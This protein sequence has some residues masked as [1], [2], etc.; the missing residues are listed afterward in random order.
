MS[1]SIVYPF[2]AALAFGQ[3]PTASNQFT[4]IQESLRH[5]HAANDTAAYL[6]ASHDLLA[7]LNGAPQSVLQLMS[8]QTFA[9]QQ[10]DALRSFGQFVAMGQAN[11]AVLRR[12]QFDALRRTPE[13]ATVHAAMAQNARS[14]SVASPVFTFPDTGLVP[15]DVDYDPTTSRFYITSVLKK[16][17]VAVTMTGQEHVFARAPDNWP[18]LALKL[19]PRRHLLWATEVAIDS[20]AASPRKDWGRSAIVIYDLATGALLHRVEG[21]AHTALGDMT[22]TAD[23][24]AIVSDGDNGGVYRVRRE[25][26]QL[27][28]L[29][30]GDFISP[31]T[32]AILPD[33]RRVLVPDY[34]RG[35]GVLDLDTKHVSWIPMDGR[36][37]LNGIDGLYLSGQTLI[38]TQNG[39][40]PERVV[41]F[42]LDSALLHV[43]SESIIERATPTLGDPTH[44]VIIGGYFYY[45][46]NSG[47]DTLDD[48]GRRKPGTTPTRASLMRTRLPNP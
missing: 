12:P 4:R 9:G 11:D 39:T 38:A 17:I 13:Y 33:G 32:P 5:A 27:E 42:T 36:H 7:L 28:R 15:E 48:H 31:Q 26:L 6:R 37:A 45:I 30:A 2:I 35:V 34:L 47:W 22:L 18:M 25:T 16:E 29:D 10:D 40:T 3:V 44:G 1:R 14:R 41:A 46:A 19:D 21:P 43:V 23:G 24:D 8:A 20:F